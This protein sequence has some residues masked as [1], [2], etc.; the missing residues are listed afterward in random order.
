MTILFPVSPETQTPVNEFSPTSTPLANTS[1]GTTYIYD[2]V[3]H[4]WTIRVGLSEIETPYITLPVD[5]AV[6]SPNVDV[7]IESSDYTIVSGNPGPHAS[8][9]WLVIEGE[10]PKISKNY[11]TEVTP[12][13]NNWVTLSP[14]N[15]VNER[16]AIYQI[17]TS[18][19]YDD[20]ITTSDMITICATGAETPNNNAPTGPVMW[21]VSNDNGLTYQRATT[22]F[23]TEGFKPVPIWYRQSWLY[24]RPECNFVILDV[25]GRSIEIWLVEKS[26]I[27]TMNPQFTLFTRN[28][29]GNGVGYPG[30]YVQSMGEF[31]NGRFSTFQMNMVYWAWGPL[32]S[33]CT[34]IDGNPYNEI[35]AGNNLLN[36]DYFLPPKPTGETPGAYIMT[37]PVCK[38]YGKVGDDNF[39]N[40]FAWSN[41]PKDYLTN[42][43]QA[44][45]THSYGED[46]MD[47]ANWNPDWYIET[48]E[49]IIQTGTI[50]DA[51]DAPELGFMVL[52]VGQSDLYTYTAPPASNPGPGKLEFIPTPFQSITLNN[53]MYDGN[54]YVLTS[55]DRRSF[56]TTVDFVHFSPVQFN[57]ITG[58]FGPVLKNND[59]YYANKKTFLST[60]MEI[61]RA[62]Q[63]YDGLKLSIDGANDPAKVE[64]GVFE[65]GDQVINY[66]GLEA[67]GT[68]LDLQ[69]DYVTLFPFGGNWTGNSTQRISTPPNQYSV[70]LDRVRDTEN[71][72]S[73]S[74]PSTVVLPGLEYRVRVRYRSINNVVSDISEYSTFKT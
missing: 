30:P 14:I 38:S 26:S 63:F 65:I 17:H 52:L 53:I 57:D 60:Q 13:N 10:L 54:F 66:E 3:D 44:F 20:P 74:L 37:Q 68:I 16:G 34:I 56:V 58:G 28:T 25:P 46:V 70:V 55:E 31:S 11:V 24:H 72:T 42:P 8:S 64:N 15:Y 67:D 49:S 12:L 5:N 6:V 61:Q 40:F 50:K 36:L 22:P 35:P 23:D 21:M 27:G 4:K 9:D 71:L 7:M 19:T 51:I 1:N 73:I 59:A 18:R 33:D 29:Y 2:P 45:V 48:Y 32:N 69:D 62:T 43:Y 41:Q 47:S 39:F